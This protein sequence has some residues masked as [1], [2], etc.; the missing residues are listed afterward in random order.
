MGVF[1]CVSVAAFDLSRR[2]IF[3][4]LIARSV[5]KQSRRD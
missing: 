5:R 4:A 3:D 1:D 2:G